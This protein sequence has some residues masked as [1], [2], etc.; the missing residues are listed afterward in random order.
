[1]STQ[2]NRFSHRERLGITVSLMLRRRALAGFAVLLM[3]ASFIFS[4]NASAHNIVL[5][6]ARE[7][8]RDFARAIRSQSNGNYIH[9]TT[10]CV[11]AYP[12][13]NHIVRCI[14]GY[15]NA[16]D[17][18]KNLYTC[19]ETIE[20]YLR[21]HQRDLEDFRERIRHT[22]RNKCGPLQGNVDYAN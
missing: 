11:L 1:M 2:E 22:A 21:P 15:Q 9:Y 7:V 5:E 14:I 12:N 8:A 3:G 19:K 4:G 13:H 16:K 17:T 10:N 20:V 18:A 6:K